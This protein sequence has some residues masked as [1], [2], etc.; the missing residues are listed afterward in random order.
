MKTAFVIRLSSIGDILITGESLEA[1][2]LQNTTP[3]LIT[4]KSFKDVAHSF[5][6]LKHCIF[7][8]HLTTSFTYQVKTNG[9]WNEA[10]LLEL[11]VSKESLVYDL[12]ATKRSSRA[13]Q[14][15]KINFPF[16]KKVSVKKRTL[17]RFFLIL[18]GYWFGQKKYLPLKTEETVYQRNLN[19][20]QNQTK[21]KIDFPNLPKLFLSCQKDVNEILKNNGIQPSFATFESKMIVIFPGASH[22]LKTWP[23]ENFLILKN[24]LLSKLP[25][26]HIIFCGSQNESSIGEY[27]DFPKHPRVHNLIGVLKLEDT[28]SLISASDAIVTNDSFPMHAAYG[29]NKRSYVIFGATS[30]EFGFAPHHSPRGRSLINVFY[31]GLSCSPCSRHGKGNCRFE[32]LLCYQKID[33]LSISQLIFEHLKTP[34]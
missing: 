9:T 29:F 17:F 3:I 22:F 24:Q 28:L 15:L 5:S 2:A 32:N 18:R 30:P 11:P 19:L 12:Q 16:L 34:S 31:S 8:D 6:V 26:H 10:S 23:K 33:P 21:K 25:H 4:Q 13:F 1:L 14:A 27:V 7:Y 20:L